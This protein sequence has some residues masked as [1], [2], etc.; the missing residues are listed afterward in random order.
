[1]L[2]PK[3]S[4]LGVFYDLSE[5]FW[6]FFVPLLSELGSKISEGGYAVSCESFF[7]VRLGGPGPIEFDYDW[8]MIS[9][10]AQLES[11]S[12]DGPLIFVYV[13]QISCNA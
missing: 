11:I 2:D 13:V 1:M 6:D 4:K 8:D 12:H 10:S 9:Y 3:W 5:P 7:H